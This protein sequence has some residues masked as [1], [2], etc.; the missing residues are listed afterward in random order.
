MTSETSAWIRAMQERGYVVCRFCETRRLYQN[1][2][3]LKSH[4]RE[5]HGAR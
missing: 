1:T 4:E 5:A 3:A 2:E